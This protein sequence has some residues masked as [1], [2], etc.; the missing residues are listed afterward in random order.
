MASREGG[1][2]VNA[3]GQLGRSGTA[4]RGSL[5][6]SPQRLWMVTCTGIWEQLAFTGTTPGDSQN[7]EASPQPP[8]LGASV[9]LAKRGCPVFTFLYPVTWVL[10]LGSPGWL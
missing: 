2:D 10:S 1:A 7:Q 4:S 5:A 6:I 8:S 9:P 3:E